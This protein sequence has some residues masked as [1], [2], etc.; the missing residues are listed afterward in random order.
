MNCTSSHTEQHFTT[1]PFPVSG[2]NNFP[3]MYIKSLDAADC[4]ALSIITKHTKTQ[5][6]CTDTAML[7]WMR[8]WMNRDWAGLVQRRSWLLAAAE[9]QRWLEDSSLLMLEWG[10][11]W[12]SLNS[13]WENRG[14]ISMKM[15]SKC[16]LA[17][18]RIMLHPSVHLRK[19]S[20][21]LEMKKAYSSPHM[22]TNSRVE[23]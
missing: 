2:S 14:H 6:C 19:D 13:E 8:F 23:E 3:W 12:S 9:I 7:A 10:S 16:L 15:T 22:H 11:N 1:F 17:H 18:I 21:L 20:T 5:P 4:S